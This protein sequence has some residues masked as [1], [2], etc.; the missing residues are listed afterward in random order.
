MGGQGSPLT[1]AKARPTAAE[2]AAAVLARLP[3][4]TDEQWNCV[5]ATLGISTTDRPSR[6][7]DQ[8]HPDRPTGAAA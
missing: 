2:W 6:T 3:R 7:T 8:D 4:L 1:D 5:N